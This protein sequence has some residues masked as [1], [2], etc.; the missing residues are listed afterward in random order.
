MP[1]KL[2]ER[3]RPRTSEATLQSA[4]PLYPVAKT[5]Q[6]ETAKLHVIENIYEQKPKSKKELCRWSTELHSV[7]ISTRNLAHLKTLQRMLLNSNRKR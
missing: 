3:G 1:P 4:P 6:K 2:S 5:G 7:W